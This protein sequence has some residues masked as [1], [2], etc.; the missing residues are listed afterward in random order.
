MKEIFDK[1]RAQT[2]VYQEGYLVMISNHNP[3]K[4]KSKKL[5]P[6]FKGP[7][8]VSSILDNNRYVISNIEGHSNRTYK[9]IFPADHLKPWFTV[10]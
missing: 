1:K 3:D 5:A 4:G 7:F 2:K 9:N 8:R 6:K 10:N